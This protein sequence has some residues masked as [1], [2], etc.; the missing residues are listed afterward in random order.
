MATKKVVLEGQS[1]W[2]RV[3][4]DNRDMKGFEGV[5]EECDGAY[6]IDVQMD[7]TNKLKLKDSGSIKKGKFDD[8]GNFSVKFV[9]KHKDRF[10]WAS[11]APTVVKADGTVWDF[12]TDGPI[13]NGSDIQVEL[14]VYSTSYSPG[15]RLEKVVVLKAAESD[16]HEPAGADEGWD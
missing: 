8:D 10:E 3:F 15:T 12:E 9:R 7:K 14:S 16:V 11:G 13:N 1:M 2:A 6:T 4:P 5:Y